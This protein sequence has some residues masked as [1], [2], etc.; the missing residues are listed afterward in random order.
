MCI[1]MCA[2]LKLPRR[3]AWR[4]NPFAERSVVVGLGAAARLAALEQALSSEGMVTILGI[5][6]FKPFLSDFGALAAARDE[7]HKSAN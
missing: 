6:I 3:L 2:V 1:C 5:E 7:F 4:A